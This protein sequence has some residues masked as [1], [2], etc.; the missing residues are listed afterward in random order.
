MAVTVGFKPDPAGIAA[1]LRG[2]NSPVAAYLLRLGA[3]VATE[4]RTR[5]GVDT[6]QTQQTIRPILDPSPVALAVRIV[7]STR[8]ALFH[9][10]GTRPHVIRPRRAKALRFVS[11]GQVIFAS[12][13]NHPGTKPNR[14]LTTALALVMTRRRGR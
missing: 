14:F 12:K 9:H 10:E 13:V 4:A 5:V 1:V 2:P 8:Y 7:A 3:E 6:S 11:G